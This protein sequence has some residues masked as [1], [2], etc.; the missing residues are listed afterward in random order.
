MNESNVIVERD[1]FV[2]MRDGVRLAVDIFRPKSEGRFPALVSISPYGKGM[3]SLPIPPQ[4]PESHLHQ[5]ARPIESGDPYFFASRGYAHVIA[6]CRGTGRSEGEYYGWMSKKEAE[7]GY[8]LIEWVAGQPWCDG[9]VGMVGIS[10][11]GTVQLSVA[12]EQ[13]PHLKVIMPWNAV[14]DFYREATHH[15]GILQTFFYYLYT[16]PIGAERSVSIVRK[17]T[18]P[19]QFNV[20]LESAKQDPDLWMYPSIYAVVDKPNKCPC[21]LDI[22]LN[23]LDGP[24]YWERSAYTKLDKIKVPCYIRSGWFAYAHMHLVGSFILYEGIK[25]PKKLLIDGPIDT[26]HPLPRDFNEEALRWF[27][28]WLKGIDTEVMNEPPIKIYVMGENRYRYETE[29]PI[30]GTKWT[31]FYLRRWGLLDTTPESH[32]SDPDVFVHRP[33]YET[34]KIESISYA[35][36]PLDSDT[37]VTGPIA[38]YLFASIDKTD[39]N[40]IVSL[41]DVAP[42]GTEVELTKGFLKASHR[43]VDEARSR[44][45]APYHPHTK[46]VP[47]EPMRV[48]EYAISLAPTS[49]VFKKGHRIKLEITSADYPGFAVPAHGRMHHPW[50]VCS[51]MTVVHRIYRDPG[52]QSHLLLPIISAR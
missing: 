31:K 44:P 13:P 2:P 23:P 11:Y 21:F 40:W 12:A 45:W 27:D 30:P 42:D 32:T 26:W 5:L 51:N 48:Y 47:V 14:A 1:V 3:Q 20:L 37:E 35:T 19:E 38:L 18:P 41:R 34:T 36:R 4:P 15:G 39:T 50:H 6:D 9:K 16:T 43:E 7:D 33:L 29:W 8:D 10:Y 17:T 28:Y 25:A 24:F 22:V 46:A 52:N 49:N